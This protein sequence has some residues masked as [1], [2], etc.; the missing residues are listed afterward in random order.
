[1]MMAQDMHDKIRELP[2]LIE[3]KEDVLLVMYK[4]GGG[5]TQCVCG[6]PV[7]AIA[8]IAVEMQDNEN[9]AKIIEMACDMYT[10]CKMNE[11][12]KNKEI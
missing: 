3:D 5:Y 10:A 8:L 11:K 4:G 2:E 9:L 7:N 12:L 6:K 1:M